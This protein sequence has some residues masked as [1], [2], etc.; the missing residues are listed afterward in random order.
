MFLEHALRLIHEAGYCVD[1]VGV[2][3]IASS[4]KIGPRREEAQAHLTALVGAPVALSATTTDG[5]GLI[6]RGEGAAALA[7]AVISAR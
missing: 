5:L 2:Q 7:T 3:I 1:S 4:P 6:G